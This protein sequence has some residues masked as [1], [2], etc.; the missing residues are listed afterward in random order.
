MQQCG[1][2]KQQYVAHV[3]KTDQAVQS[4]A[5]HLAEVAVIA[6]KISS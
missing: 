6:K 3:R 5:E 2:I 1:Q 4:L